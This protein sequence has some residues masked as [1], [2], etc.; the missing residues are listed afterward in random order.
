MRTRHQDHALPRPCEFVRVGDDSAVG[1]PIS[2][3]PM[4]VFTV[5]HPHRWVLDN[6]LAPISLLA[7]GMTAV[8]KRSG[9]AVPS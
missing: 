8:L 6:G 3:L 5:L 7:N 2:I 1:L 4:R 9:R